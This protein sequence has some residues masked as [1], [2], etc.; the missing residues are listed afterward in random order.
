MAF[1]PNG[2][3]YRTAQAGFAVAGNAAL[4]QGLPSRTPR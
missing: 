2:N 3:S 1:N 4:D